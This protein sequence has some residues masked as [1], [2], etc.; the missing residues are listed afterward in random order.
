ME[1]FGLMNLF[2]ER[3]N[4]YRTKQLKSLYFQKYLPLMLQDLKSL[5]YFLLFALLNITELKG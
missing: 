5:L 4:L 1:Q 3:F 2:Y